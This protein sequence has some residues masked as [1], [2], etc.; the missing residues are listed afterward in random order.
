MDVRQEQKIRT[1]YAGGYGAMPFM[2]P[3][4]NR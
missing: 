3:V 1:R 2:P 4:S